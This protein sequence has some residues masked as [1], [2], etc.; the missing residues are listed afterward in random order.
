MFFSKIRTSYIMRS[1]A[2]TFYSCSSTKQVHLNH[3]SNQV[4]GAADYIWRKVTLI[5]GVQL[6][7]G[8]ALLCFLLILRRAQMLTISLYLKF[9]YPHSCQLGNLTKI[10]QLVKN[11]QS[12]TLSRF[13]LWSFHFII[14]Y[15][16]KWLPGNVNSSSRCTNIAID[17][18]F[19]SKILVSSF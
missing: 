3:I 12:A 19:Y 17:L 16:V 8:V 10:M 11:C 1:F 7:S 18:K 15:Q 9:E 6:L 14:Y 5:S 13:S 4:G 2:D